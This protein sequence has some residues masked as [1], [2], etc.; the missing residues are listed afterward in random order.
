M[1]ATRTATREQIGFEPLTTDH[2]ACEG[3]VRTDSAFSNRTTYLI[4]LGFVLLFG[5]LVRFGMIFS[6]DFPLND[7]GMF[8][9]AIIDL[10]HAHYALPQVIHYNGLSLPYAYPP[11]GFYIAGLLADSTHASLFTILRFVPATFSMLTLAAFMLLANSYLRR[12]DT[13]VVASLAFALV[14]RSYNWEIMGGGLTRSIG[15]F[16]AMLAIWQTYLLFT[17]RTRSAL[18][19]TT[20]FAALA[21]V[22]H[23]EIAWFVAF[24][25]VL[26]IL[27][28]RRT[29]A[30]LRDS[31]IVSFGVLVLTSPWWG[32]VIARFGFGPFIN[33][34]QSGNHSVIAIVALLLRLNWGEEPL[35]PIF[36]ALALI[37]ILYSVA[38]RRYFLPLWVVVGLALDPRKFE[39]EAMVP[40]SMLV[41]ICVIDVI[42]PIV[43][44]RLASKPLT[45]EQ[46]PDR[47]DRPAR[48]GRAWTGP[49]LVGILVIY[50][51]MSAMIATAS[52]D[53]AL[54]QSERQAMEWARTS[55]APDSRF[56]IVTGDQWG[57]DRTSEWFPLLADRT[58]AATV[59]G[60]EWLPN[61][62]YGKQESSYQKLQKC[63]SETVDCI[64]TWAAA[65][66]ASFDY[67]YIATR[68][69][70]DGTFYSHMPC[71]SGLVASF[72]SDSNYA[73]VFQN[74][75]AAIFELKSA[76]AQA[77]LAGSEI[78]D[79][80]RRQKP[81]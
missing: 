65:E 14:P 48:R 52:G 15:F 31:L 5:A 60:Y 17:R 7:G 11:L 9:Q 55:T 71:C 70:Q 61:G 80:G 74:D 64:D 12:R 75:G 33:A 25:A 43:N 69:L 73:L 54:A 81:L 6:V 20:L 28:Y 16:F 30:G 68:K 4:A 66:H 77:D 49:I 67:V 3:D 32:S 41:G 51:M 35:F 24:S 10:Q 47:I 18:V 23:L 34:A 27:T 8:M 26:L 62:A 44:H 79:P 57:S 37:G 58:S 36:G 40:L 56:T 45:D 2:E 19:W 63:A 39:T 72:K 22:S 1:G 46:L 76:I 29:L 78:I 53:V 13:V 38:R 50:S 21:C 59:Q 42:V